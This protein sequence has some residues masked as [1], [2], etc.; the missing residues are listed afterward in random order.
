MN[1]PVLN[2]TLWFPSVQQAT[3][4][5][6]VALGGDLSEDR[7]LLAYRSGIFP[8]FSEDEPIIWWSP[9]P[10]FV[11]FPKDLK[12]SKSMR[13]LLSKNRFEV[14]YNQ[15]FQEVI[16]QC[17]L[18]KRHQQQDGTWITN[19]MIDAY[20]N[21][22]RR[23][24]AHSVEVWEAGDLVG[25]LYGIRIG[26]C[27]FG[28]SM[29]H[30]VSNASKYGFIKFIEQLRKEGIVIVDCQVYTPHL[31]SLGAAY[32]RRSEF[33]EIISGMTGGDNF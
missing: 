18:T 31:E 11:L 27:F 33:L 23:G 7:L 20:V 26:K 14:T 16:S 6:I 1:I 28:E 21:L 22:Y 2:K 10:R 25:G 13:L 32:I 24:F 3:K 29:F 9:D 30:T 8:W 12:I 17:A 15:N 19:E 5:G 4:E